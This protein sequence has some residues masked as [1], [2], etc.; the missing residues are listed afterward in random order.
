MRSTATRSDA[1]DKLVAA[2]QS[3]VRANRR[4]T[5]SALPNLRPSAG[6]ARN[7]RRVGTNADENGAR[8]GARGG[9]RQ[10]VGYR[11]SEVTSPRCRRCSWGRDRYLIA[12][13]PLRVNAA[14]IGRCSD[15]GFSTSSLAGSFQRVGWA[16]PTIPLQNK[17]SPARGGGQARRADWAGLAGISE[18]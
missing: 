10:A 2:L 1:L 11:V 8:E 18:L 6:G 9:R 4:R 12:F 14:V 5:E 7:Q 13:G 16:L 3:G 15:A 17:Y